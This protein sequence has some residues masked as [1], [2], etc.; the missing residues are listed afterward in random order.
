MY[1]ED[2]ILF[3][4]IDVERPIKWT[5]IRKKDEA[6][7]DWIDVERPIKWTFIQ[8]K[9]KNQNQKE[10]NQKEKKEKKFICSSFGQ[11]VRLLSLPYS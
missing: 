4:W 5:L 3:G 9:S 11:N 10:K 7:I 6:L 8:K 2:E 1:E